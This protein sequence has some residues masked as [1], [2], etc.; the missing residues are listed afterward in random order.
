MNCSTAEQSVHETISS[1]KFAE[2]AKKIKVN[3]QSLEEEIV[4]K[5]SIEQLHS[6]I[7]KLQYDLEITTN[8]LKRYQKKDSQSI[9]KTK[10]Q[11]QRLSSN[12]KQ[13]PSACPP[14]KLTPIDP[15]P[16]KRKT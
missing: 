11:P 5:E 14:L 13:T 4:E 16:Y 1:L 15:Q 12:K 8:E 9:Q 6:I 2:R 7:K 10:I 3:V